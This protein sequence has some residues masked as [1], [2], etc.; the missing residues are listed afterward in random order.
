M[1]RK[2]L[3]FGSRATAAIAVSF[4]ALS[5]CGGDMSPARVAP[6]IPPPPL[7][8]PQNL[9]VTNGAGNYR[10]EDFIEWRWDAVPGA[11][12]YQVE[13]SVADDDFNPPDQQA[14]LAASDTSVRFPHGQL[15]S[16]T[17]VYLRARAFGGSQ[18]S[19]VYGPFSEPVGGVTG[20]PPLDSDR[21]RLVLLYIETGGRRHWRT[22]TG[23]LTSAPLRDWY[24]V[25]TDAGERVVRLSLAENRLAGH[26]PAELG[27]LTNLA[28]LNLRVNGLSGQ[29]PPE[30]GQL[31][32]LAY[33]NLSHNDTGPFY[34]FS[35]EIPPELGQLT[36]L[37]YLNLSGNDLN[38][39][40]PPELGQ[41]KNLEYLKLGIPDLGV[42][43]YIPSNDLTGKGP[44]RTRPTHESEVSGSE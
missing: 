44:A 15:P 3:A 9:Q 30:L 18:T 33:L 7:G 35:G 39:E 42:V 1:K 31:T 20:I 25:E 21:D 22:D 12:G 36:S 4:A 8:I 19:P 38:G 23:W 43:G 10:G 16:G 34:G 37:E 2:K 32:K 27:Q 24:G 11:A 40:I 17:T 41:L 29:I 26:L 5:A 14:I 13:V 28:Y 6:L